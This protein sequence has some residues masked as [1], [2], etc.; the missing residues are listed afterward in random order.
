MAVFGI[1]VGTNEDRVAQVTCFC[2]NDVCSY[3]RKPSLERCPDLSII[4]FSEIEALNNLVIDV[5][6]KL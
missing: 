3:V 6:L 4:S 5:A 1:V 2:F